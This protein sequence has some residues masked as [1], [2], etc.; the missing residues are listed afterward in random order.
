MSEDE[1]QKEEVRGL[2]ATALLVIFVSAILEGDKINFFPPNFLARPIW[3][4][5]SI[6][7]DF[8]IPFR[9]IAGAYTLLWA[10]YAFFMSLA[11]SDDAGKLI[12]RNRRILQILV[13]W[14]FVR[15]F[16]F[17]AN[18]SFFI[19]LLVVV[20]LGLLMSLWYA[21]SLGFART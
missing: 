9:A 4:L 6:I 20:S 3:P 21:W 14:K 11:Y 15:C 8:V 13:R 12:L 19:G 5:N 10:I 18:L 2:F 1:L 7:P 16:K 17:V